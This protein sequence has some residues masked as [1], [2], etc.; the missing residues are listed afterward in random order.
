LRLKFLITSLTSCSG[1]I[2]SLISLDIFSQFLER[3][4]ILYF[5]FISDDSEIEICDIALIEGCISEESQINYLKDIRISAKKVF[6]LGTCAA[7]GGILCLSKKTKAAPISDYIEVDGIIPGCPPSS[8]LLGN[9]LIKL[10]ER[11]NIEL[12]PKNLC[13]E[14]P[15]K[16]TLKI[17]SKIEIDH[18][19]PQNNEINNNE[20]NPTCFLS[21]GILCMGPITREGCDY[22]C[23]KRGIPCEGCMGPV[24]KDYTSNLI[25]YLSLFH[26]V[27][28]LKKYSGI[29]Y[30]FSKPRIWR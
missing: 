20:N 2:S 1:C 16:N 5:P 14:C 10:L 17:N 30:R 7:F 18:I 26:L 19:Y 9:C 22:E 6:A 23:I 11:K 12:P 4:D 24:S 28:D 27:K 3:T 21:K 8:K 29:F 13:T 15:Y 25:N